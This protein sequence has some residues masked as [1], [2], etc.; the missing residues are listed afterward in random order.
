[1]NKGVMAGVVAI[2]IAVV[3]GAAVW[4]MKNKSGTASTDSFM[5]AEPT[6]GLTA[7]PTSSVTEDEAT[8]GA[9]IAGVKEFTVTE[10]NFRFNPA[11]IRV[12]KGDTVRV[13]FQSKDLMH[14]FTIDE[15][16]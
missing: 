11:E 5:T 8:D 13:L 1:M 3:V 4:M 15:Y 14:D 7:E 9:T 12:K 10:A 16:E 6:Q 2:L